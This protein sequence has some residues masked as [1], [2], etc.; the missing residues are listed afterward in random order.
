MIGI[1]DEFLDVSSTVKSAKGVV[2][3]VK[4][5]AE[6]AIHEA[7]M[8]TEKVVEAGASIATFKEGYHLVKSGVQRA[9]TTLERFL[10]NPMGEAR[11][12]IVDV[13]PIAEDAFPYVEDAAMVA[14]IG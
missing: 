6:S 13:G 8:V 4:E 7:E 2:S 3:S 10:A 14:A 5:K 12:M 9:A 11:S 1:N